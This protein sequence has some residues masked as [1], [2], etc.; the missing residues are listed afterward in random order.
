MNVGVFV[1]V[2]HQYVAI[3]SRYDKKIDYLRYLNQAVGTSELY[4]AI[5]FGAQ[6]NNEA[7]GFIKRLKSFGYETRYKQAPVLNGQPVLG[8]TDFVVEIIL[9]I[10]RYLHKL[11]R[12]V[13]GSSDLRLIPVIKF[14]QERGIR[15]TVLACGIPLEVA[16][17]ANSAIEIPETILETGR[18]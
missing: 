4:C 2:T 6:I 7:A 12:I 9:D 10:F 15:V 8:E 5:A 13:I 17:I 18:I 14:L 3:K 11:D 16:R 1:D